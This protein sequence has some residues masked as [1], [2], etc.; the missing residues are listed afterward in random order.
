MTEISF[1]TIPMNEKATMLQEI[2]N[3]QGLAPFAV[4]KDWWVVQ[5]LSIGLNIN[6][7]FSQNTNL[8]M[9]FKVV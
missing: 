6:N 4:E 8:K 2:S 3:K 9:V 5:K 1:H 7:Q